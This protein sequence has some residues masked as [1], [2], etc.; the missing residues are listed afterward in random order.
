MS[1]PHVIV[2]RPL[3]LIFVFLFSCGVALAEQNAVSIVLRPASPEVDREAP[4]NVL[5][6]ETSAGKEKLIG[7]TR[8]P[9]LLDAAQLPDDFQLVVR[10]SN[11]H[12]VTPFVRRN[13]TRDSLFKLAKASPDG[14]AQLEYYLYPRRVEITFKVHPEDAKLKLASISNDRLASAQDS[15]EG[16]SGRLLVDRLQFQDPEGIFHPFRVTVE[17]EGYVP[18]ELEVHPLKDFQGQNGERLTYEDPITLTPGSGLS[19]RWS[20]LLYWHKSR[21]L[22]T[23][24]VEL[25]VGLLG[26]AVPLWLLPLKRRFDQG[27]RKLEV[28]EAYENRISDED[29]NFG[30]TI[31]DYRI[32]DRL[33]RGGM[34]TVYKGIP[35][36]LLS[37]DIE[38][39]ER[40]SVAVKVMHQEY[41]ENEDFRKRFQREIQVC[42]ELNHRNV[43]RLINWG[44]QDGVLFLVMEMVDGVT[45]GEHMS[46]PMKIDR[47]C[48]L[49]DGICQG[50]SHAHSKG[51]VHR[52]LKPANI[53]VTQRGLVKIM[54]MGLAKADKAEH[55]VT[56]TG[57][58][59]GTLAYMPPEQ[60]TG[61][62]VTPYA[63]QYSLGVMAYEMLA[64]RLPFESEGDPMNFMLKHLNEIPVSLREWRPNLPDGLDR[65]ILRMLSKEPAKRFPDLRACL[66]EVLTTGVV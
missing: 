53:M 23:L 4:S 31:G 35:D 38:T 49:F 14:T 58:A 44:N 34:A 11:K 50:L 55:K 16:T 62:V 61:G 25:G 48:E 64:G 12:G 13:L 52:D 42:Q 8:E 20:Q 59:L 33:G 60:F 28:I 27:R 45:L 66:D 10:P 43:V 41:A 47:F 2:R 36:H 57:D 39:C 56:Q 15:N 26:L 18:T 6:R 54:D 65:A 40:S 24:G 22:L 51:I 3:V 21:P 29:P 17:R 32:V 30:K 5:L 19:D 7:K 37:T 1:R 46:E 63:D 9:I